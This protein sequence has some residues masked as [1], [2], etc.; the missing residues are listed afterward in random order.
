MRRPN[1]ISMVHAYFF[2]AMKQMWKWLLSMLT[3]YLARQKRLIYCPLYLSDCN[4]GKRP[5]FDVCRSVNK[6]N[7]LLI[8]C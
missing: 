4:I 1:V 7:A 3:G 2:T 6:Q 5:R 8:Q